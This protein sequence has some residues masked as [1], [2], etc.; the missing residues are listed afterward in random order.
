M[1]LA[2]IPL[3]VNPRFFGVKHADFFFFKTMA[4]PDRV[5]YVPLHKGDQAIRSS[6]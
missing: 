2:L 6:F 5:A 4:E 1:N 3:K